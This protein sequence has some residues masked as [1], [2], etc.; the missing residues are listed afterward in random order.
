MNAPETARRRG[1]AAVLRRV[2]RMHFWLALIAAPALIVL[3]CSRLVIL[4]SQPLDTWLNRDLMVVDQGR[5]TVSLD[6]QVATAR[7][8]VGAEDTLDAVTPPA[9]S[10]RSTRVDFLT[11]QAAAAE[12]G[13]TDLTQVFIDP[14]T[15]QYL[16]QRSQL[17]GLVGWANQ[18][19]RMFG[20]DAP[21]L[22]L[23]SLG[24]LIDSE[25]HPVATIPVGIG[26]LWIELTAVWLLVLLATGIYLWWPRAIEAAKPLLR[27]GWR[28]GGRI[29]WR[30]LHALT[31]VIVAVVLVCYVLSGMTWSRYWGENW[32]AFSSTV[33]PS[34]QIDAPSTPAKMGDFD[35]LGRR[36]AAPTAGVK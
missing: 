18:L 8:H 19:H 21:T 32:R 22:H 23:P 20:N 34:T 30:E 26:N 7:A 12:T 25:A 3:A 5:T 15:G 35:R 11:P 1:N 33:A 28:P 14:Y 24:H 2:W 4:Y 27:L 10:D 17:S 9:G 16:G 36:K 13:E 31:G 29:R 6:N